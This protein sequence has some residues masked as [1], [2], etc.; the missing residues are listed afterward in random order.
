MIGATKLRGISSSIQKY[1][2]K[3]AYLE[4]DLRLIAIP[5]ALLIILLSLLI[6]NNIIKR[7]IPQA[8]RA[9]D[10]PS[11]TVVSYPVM[12]TVFSP[13]VTAKAAYVIDDTAKVVLYAKNPELRFSM[14][15]TTKIMTALVALE[16][17][18][19][20]S[21][22]TVQ[23][24]HKEGSIV[25][26][27]PGE[28]L[29]FI[30]L[31]YGLLLPS[32]N[33][34]AY[35]MADNYPGGISSFVARMNEKAREFNLTNTQYTDPAGLDDEGGYTTV[36]DLARLASYALKNQTIAQI[37]S[38]KQIT[39]TTVDGTKEYPLQNLNKLLGTDGV[40]GVKTGFT[41]GAG[42]VL[43]TSKKE[44]DHQFILVVMKSDDRFLDTQ[45]L[46]SL[47]T[48]NIT[49]YHP[50]YTQNSSLQKFTK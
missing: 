13:Q 20:D 36:I 29:H 10:R 27:K 18:Q 28:Q 1:N 4:E 23:N 9:H 22:L 47:I 3:L 32:G 34:A 6:V 16:Y 24:E 5:L 37:V 7:Q 11:Y 50:S 49:Y 2:K 31:L 45:N 44:Q 19:R 39:I 33:D 40:N 38:T 14:A 42:G 26:L 48:N 17:F 21:I 35:A 8:V 41:E 30:D 46:L 15:S 25:G 12:S 43:I